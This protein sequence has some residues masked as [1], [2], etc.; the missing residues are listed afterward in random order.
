M[1]GRSDLLFCRLY[2]RRSFFLAVVDKMIGRER[3]IEKSVGESLNI[4]LVLSFLFRGFAVGL[5]A[6]GH[7]DSFKVGI[8]VL[9]LLVVVKIVVTES[10]N[11]FAAYEHI[12]YTVYAFPYEY[13]GRSQKLQKIGEITS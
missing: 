11:E 2:S 12:L 1:Y 13:K 9:S 3:Y 10:V 8:E 7:A 5:F 6:V 4:L